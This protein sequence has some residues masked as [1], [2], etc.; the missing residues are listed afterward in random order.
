[1][2]FELSR[3]KFSSGLLH[4]FTLTFCLFYSKEDKQNFQSF[5]KCRSVKVRQKIFRWF[6]LQTNFKAKPQQVRFLSKSVF[7]LTCLFCYFKIFLQCDQYINMS[8][9]RRELENKKNPREKI[10]TQ[11]VHTQYALQSSTTPLYTAHYCSIY[12]VNKCVFTFKFVCIEQEL[13]Y[14]SIAFITRCGTECLKIEFLNTL[15]LSYSSVVH[16]VEYRRSLWLKV[17]FII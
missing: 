11:C 4:F 7:L 14:T 9:S 10:V 17:S 6:R 15:Q 13:N 8:I 3:Q 12:L 2:E 5:L 16:P 1:M